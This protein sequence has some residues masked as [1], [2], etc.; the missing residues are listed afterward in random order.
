VISGFAVS[1]DGIRA[2]NINSARKQ[3]TKLE[4]DKRQAEIDHLHDH[5][6]HD[7]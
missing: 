5:D 7:H 6:H 2:A 3:N 1:S 4:R